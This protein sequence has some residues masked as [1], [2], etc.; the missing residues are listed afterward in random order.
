M[1]T[2]RRQ[3]ADTKTRKRRPRPIPSRLLET[4][5]ELDEMARRRCLMILSVLSGE[6]SVSDAI[7]KAQISR[8][9]YYDLEERALGAMLLA[10]TPG[11]ETQASSPQ[12]RIAQLEERCKKLEQDKRRSER[13]L[14]LTRRVIKPGTLKSAK[15]R[16]PK[17]RKA[18]SS[19]PRGSKPSPS[20]TSSKTPALASSP[21]SGSEPSPT[22][23]GGVAR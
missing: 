23:D 22:K 9:F 15:G 13:L 17:K 6:V 3:P 11:S 18:A 5:S 21:T 14:F 2:R 10:L 1:S 4:S 12:A 7:E 20:S 19:T 8:A 16:P